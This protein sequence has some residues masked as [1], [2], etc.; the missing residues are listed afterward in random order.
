MKVW[1]NHTITDAAEAKISVIDHGLL[2]GDG[3]FE[4]IRIAERGIFR[5]EDH[6]ARLR[7]SARAIGLALPWDD[8]FLSH[9]LLSRLQQR[10]AKAMRMSD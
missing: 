7:V 10:T 2:Y 8:A 9:L 3:V 1:I 5:L 6:L 4:G